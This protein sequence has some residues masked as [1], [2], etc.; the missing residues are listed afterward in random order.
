MPTYQTYYKNKSYNSI[1]IADY[2]THRILFEPHL[3]HH[4]SYFL[5]TQIYSMSPN[6]RIRKKQM[7]IKLPPDIDDKIRSAVESGE[8]TNYTDAITG[9]LRL[10]FQ[11]TDVAKLQ[12]EI[13]A[14][15]NDVE[16]LKMRSE[17]FEKKLCE[18][19]VNTKR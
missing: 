10:Y 7:S 5:R 9:M 2:S 13:T 16:L 14:L 12:E 6:T 19:T 3:S 11:N 8:F 15:K 1:D 18:V 4:H 17:Y